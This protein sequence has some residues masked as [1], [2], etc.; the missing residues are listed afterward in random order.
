VLTGGATVLVDDVEQAL[1]SAC[2]AEVIV[3]GVPNARLGQVVAAVL[4]DRQAVPAARA[5][6]RA[7]APAERPRLWFSLPR[8]PVT[9]AGKVDRAGIIELARSGA[10]TPIPRAASRSAQT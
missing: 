2:G 1:R 4:T 10:L 7:L 6:A 3:F 5:A 9:T 8:W